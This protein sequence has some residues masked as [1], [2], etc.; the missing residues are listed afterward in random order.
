M[1]VSEESELVGGGKE[2]RGVPVRGHARLKR[3]RC[4]SGNGI[5]GVGIENIIRWD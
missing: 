1:G 4:S 5:I 2:K 3:G